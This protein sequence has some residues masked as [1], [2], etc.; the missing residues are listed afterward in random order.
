[1]VKPPDFQA[2]FHAM[3]SPLLVVT[4]AAFTI[5]AVNDAYLQATM[6]TRDGILGRGL[7]EVFPDGPRRLGRL[8][9][10]PPEQQ[11]T[12]SQAPAPPGEGTGRSDGPRL[13]RESLERVVAEHRPDTMPMTRYPIPRPQHGDEAG[14]EERWW[15]P[16]NTPVL[17]ARGEVA[18]I[19]HE[20]EDVTGRMRE[21]QAHGRNRVL[22]QLLQRQDSVQDEERSRMA[23]EL[24]GGLGQYLSSLSLALA[25]LASLAERSFRPDTTEQL[26]RLQS[27]TALIDLELERMILDLRP[28]SLDDCGLDEGVAGYLARWSELTGVATEMAVQGFDAARLPRAVENGVFRVV[29]EGLNNV[30]QHAGAAHVGITLQQRPDSVSGTVED[31]GVGFAVDQ[32][33]GGDTRSGLLGARERIEALG[34]RFEVDSSPGGGTTLFW[35][36]PLH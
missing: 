36:V 7:F 5:V 2:L 19:L 21:H 28:T 23:R 32:T 11:P 8:P 24:Q 30:A 6:T 3:P 1:M 18:C 16:R 12:T 20:V 26:R 35:H 17:D 9:Q 14:F 4:P 25:S 22:R 27:L 34:G 13:L 10:Q 15:Q 31:D 29:Q 33:A